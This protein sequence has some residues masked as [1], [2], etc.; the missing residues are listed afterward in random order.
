MK[1]LPPALLHQLEAL[2]DET[3]RIVLNT[4]RQGHWEIEITARFQLDE[5]PTPQGPQTQKSPRIK[6]SRISY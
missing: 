6:G 2:P 4:N 3:F 5:R 1:P